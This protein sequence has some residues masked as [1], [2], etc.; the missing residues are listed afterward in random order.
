MQPFEL[1]HECDKRV[2]CVNSIASAETADAQAE[3]TLRTHTLEVAAVD[4]QDTVEA[5]PA[6]GAD[7]TLGIGV[8]VWGSDGRAD[9]PHALAA[10][11]LAKPVGCANSAGRI[12][13]HPTRD[14]A[15]RPPR[16]PHPRIQPRRMNPTLRTPQGKIHRRGRLGG[17]I[18]E[19]H[20]AAA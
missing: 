17:L 8:R 10:E 20:R 2:G 19:Y 18:H 3:P 13:G 14:R 6:E 9:Y 12:Y 11:D 7:P 16:R 4:D 15:P 5:L 1:R